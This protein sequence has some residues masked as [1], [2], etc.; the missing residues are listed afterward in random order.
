MVSFDN[1]T[2][3]YG[4]IT[5]LEDISF[6]V[7]PGEFVFITGPSG[8]GKST[9]LKLLLRDTKPERGK[10]LIEGKDIS[11]L[12]SRDLPFYRRKVGVVFQD[13]KL[14]WGRTVW[15]NVALALEV[16]GEQKGDKKIKDALNEVGLLERADLF[17]RQLAGGEQQR[18]VIARALVAKPKLILADEPTGN[19]DP[20][21]S[22]QIIELLDRQA[23][24]D[25]T[26]IIMA[27]HN[28]NI[29]NT[30][31]RRVLLF[32]NGKLVSDKKS[33]KYQ[34]VEIKNDKPH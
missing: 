4:S 20:A 7:E 28:E 21:T 32:K 31:K 14:L 33:G 2:K 5:A 25:G 12:K 16:S 24:E 34:E 6:E 1:V 9:V 22:R 15:E 11:T 29:V 26:T 17:P 30:L 23:K 8:A 18:V 10:I 3:K 19:L 27:T 13:F